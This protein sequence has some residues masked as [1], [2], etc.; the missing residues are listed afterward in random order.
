MRIRSHC[1]T[2]AK[3]TRSETYSNQPICD[4]TDT[5]REVEVLLPF[6]A[7]VEVAELSERREWATQRQPKDIAY[8]LDGYALRI[9][10]VDAYD[11]VP[12]QVGFWELM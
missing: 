8:K 10:Q 7:P 1:A 2:A 4:T 5:R 9:E 3:A 6:W 11:K 12:G